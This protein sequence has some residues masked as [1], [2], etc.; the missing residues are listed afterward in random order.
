MARAG[1]NMGVR[2]IA[3]LAKVSPSTVARFEAGEDLLPR[4]VESIQRVFEDAGVTFTNGNAPGLRLGGGRARRREA[5]T[6]R[7]SLG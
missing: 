1:L 4:T 3:D 6:R 2:E 7:R 5:A